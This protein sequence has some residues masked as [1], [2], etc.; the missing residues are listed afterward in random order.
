[1]PFAGKDGKFIPVFLT[2]VLL[3]EAGELGGMLLVAEDITERK[4][5]EKRLK[6]YAAELERSNRE[7]QESSIP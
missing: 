2:V 5:A 3:K 4:Q 7:L 1:M 6:T